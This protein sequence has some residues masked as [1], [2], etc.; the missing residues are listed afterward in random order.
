MNDKFEKLLIK[1]AMGV[2]IFMIG[3][4]L[5]FAFFI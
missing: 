4:A 3:M 1:I 5:I 2:V